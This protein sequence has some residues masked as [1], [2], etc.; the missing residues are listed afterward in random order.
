MTEENRLIKTVFNIDNNGCENNW[1][2]ELKSILC[3]IGLTDY[4]NNKLVTNMNLAEL[5]M[6][7]FYGSEWSTRV[8]Q[9]PKLR[10]V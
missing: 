4:Y 6:K 10:T 9:S 5:K 2:S 7:Q 1:C 3:R 8:Q